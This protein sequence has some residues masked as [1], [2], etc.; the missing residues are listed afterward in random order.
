MNPILN[1]TKN[2][3]PFYEY[4]TDRFRQ[5]LFRHL[6][7][8]ERSH[9]RVLS[10]V[11]RRMFILGENLFVMRD[12]GVQDSDIGYRSCGKLDRWRRDT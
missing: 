5:H 10:R 7:R 12:C 6:R 8:A 4:S 11:P 3:D 9:H 1:R 2:Q